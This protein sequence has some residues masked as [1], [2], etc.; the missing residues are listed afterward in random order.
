M[1]FYIRNTDKK[2]EAFARAFSVLQDVAVV[3]FNP[4]EL[5]FMDK[6]PEIFPDPS[7]VS[8]MNAQ[9]NAWFED[10]ARKNT[11]TEVEQKLEEMCQLLEPRT[12]ETFKEMHSL[13]YRAQEPAESQEPCNLDRAITTCVV[14]RDIIDEKLSNLL[15]TA[16]ARLREN[17]IQE[18][19]VKVFEVIAADQ[20]VP[21][22]VEE[23]DF[24]DKYLEEKKT[25]S[26]IGSSRIETEMDTWYEDLILNNA[27]DAKEQQIEEMCRTLEPK[28]QEI[29]RE[30]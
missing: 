23:L 27:L 26:A 11:L 8:T 10:Q 24:M 20:T 7:A 25:P 4:E 18:E 13:F 29:F 14:I 21:F 17:M 1:H 16:D 28:I 22:S 2:K 9:M 15:R 19:F 5:E 30:K 6:Y 12:K 3:P